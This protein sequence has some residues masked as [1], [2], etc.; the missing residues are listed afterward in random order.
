[1][2]CGGELESCERGFDLIKLDWEIDCELWFE[3]I[4]RYIGWC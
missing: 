4:G 2:D 3:Y 1:M